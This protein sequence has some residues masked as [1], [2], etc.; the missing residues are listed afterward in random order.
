MES[1]HPFGA[2]QCCYHI[3]TSSTNRSPHH[4][5]S[6]IKG[7]SMKCKIAPRVQSKMIMLLIAPRIGD[8]IMTLLSELYY[9]QGICANE[10]KKV[11]THLGLWIIII[12]SHTCQWMTPSSNKSFSRE[13][14]EMKK[15]SGYQS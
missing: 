5:Q 11:C 1:L 15:S 13:V 9:N 8:G 4:Q 2:I 3:L 14:S 10:K 12:S 6:L 7:R